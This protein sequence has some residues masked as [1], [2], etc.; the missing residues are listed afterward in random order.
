MRDS[1]SSFFQVEQTLIVWRCSSFLLWN[2][3]KNN[4]STIITW[5][6][7][8][9]VFWELVP[10]QNWFKPQSD[11]L[12]TSILDMVRL[13]PDWDHLSGKHSDQLFALYQGSL[14]YFQ[15]NP[16]G[17]FWVLGPNQT[18]RVHKR[19]QKKYEYNGIAQTCI[20]TWHTKYICRNVCLIPSQ[21]A[22]LCEGNWLVEHMKK[23]MQRNNTNQWMKF[24]L[25]ETSII[26]S[27]LL[28]LAQNNKPKLWFFFL[29]L[30]CRHETLPL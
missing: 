21:A 3:N 19:S 5:Q 6:R 15:T 7:K 20:S 25:L 16:K 12:H 8:T 2:A 10:Y 1:I 4:M 18:A 30:N 22:H 13:E 26:V 9:V 28:S 27:Y 29:L 11:C 23:L 24:N 14:V 17:T